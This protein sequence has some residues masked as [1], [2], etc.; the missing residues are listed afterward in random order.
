LPGYIATDV[1]KT[2]PAELLEKSVQHLQW[3]ER[4]AAVQI[5]TT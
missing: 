5:S 4:E 3:Q 1:V 2:V